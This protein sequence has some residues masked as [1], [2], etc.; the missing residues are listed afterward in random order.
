VVAAA[1]V[2]AAVL[3]DVTFGWALHPLV[4]VQAAAPGL[5]VWILRTYGLMVRPPAR[6]WRELTGRGEGPGR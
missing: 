5:V 4:W 3:P 1:V 2:L 6:S